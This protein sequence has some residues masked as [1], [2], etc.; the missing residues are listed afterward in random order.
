[1]TDNNVENIKK[2]K[3]FGDMNDPEFVKALEYAQ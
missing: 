3:P 2:L 1:M